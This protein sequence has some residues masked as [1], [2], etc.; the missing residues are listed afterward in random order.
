MYEVI[1]EWAKGECVWGEIKVLYSKY[2]SFEGNFCRNI[3][4]LVN[5]LRNIEAI[6]VMCNKVS[7]INKIKGYPEKL[8][9]DI[10]TTDSLYI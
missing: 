3:L 1:S 6:A 5:L 8:S 10:V 4:R 2:F 7:L 9:R